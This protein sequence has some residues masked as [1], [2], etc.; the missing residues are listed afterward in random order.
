[1]KKQKNKYEI[2]IWEGIEWRIRCFYAVILLV[3]I[4]LVIALVVLLK[5]SGV[6]TVLPIS[7]VSFIF[8]I[9]FGVLLKEVYIKVL[10]YA[11]IVLVPIGALAITYCVVWNWSDDVLKKAEIL[12]FAGQFLAFCGAF[13]LGYFIFANEQVNDGKSNQ[14]ISAF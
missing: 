8:L 1:M 12:E 10:F 11:P 13:C 14:K 7:I 3:I 5:K 6:G 2:D 4:F 9:I